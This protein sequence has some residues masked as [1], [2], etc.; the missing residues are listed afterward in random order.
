MA[1]EADVLRSITAILQSGER[2]EQ[3]KVQSALAMMQFSAQQRQQD[4]AQTQANLDLVS[5]SVQQQKPQV[6]AEFLASSGI[7]G[8][9]EQ[10]AEDEPA[11]DSIGRMVKNLRSKQYFGR[12]FDETQAESMAAAVWNYYNAQDPNSILKLAG[13]LHEANRMAN[14]PEQA[15][16]MSKP[17]KQLYEAFAKLHKV[18]DL[19]TLTMSAKKTRDAESQVR[20]EIFDFTKGDYDISDLSGIYSGIPGAL[21]ELDFQQRMEEQPPAAEFTQME[22]TREALRDAEAR[23]K[24]LQN[25]MDTNMATDDEKEEF[26]ELP[27]LIDRFRSEVGE[28]S[29]SL[30]DLAQDELVDLDKQI[31]DM[32]DAGL[33][34]TRQYKEIKRKR[35]EKRREF[36]NLTRQS[37]QEKRREVR[38][39]EIENVSELLGV[40]ASEAESHYETAAKSRG[41]PDYGFGSVYPGMREAPEGRAGEEWTLKPE[42]G[43]IGT[44]GQEFIELLEAIGL[45]QP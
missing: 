32:R 17:Q 34:R 45:K 10:G 1:T 8:I 39:K 26:Y 2:R 21:D 24:G 4:I 18:S 6:A 33:S 31:E 37:A 13:D 25:K 3:Y 11:S 20:K 36:F 44:R 9:Y 16:L 30:Q 28:S 43:W 35:V 5:K 23:L 22:T 42:G 29:A 14:N 19:K 15:G 12:K 38:S 7:G 40:S 41:V 27:N